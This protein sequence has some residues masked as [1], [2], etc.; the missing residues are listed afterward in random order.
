MVDV[1]H[2]GR[3]LDIDIEAM[4]ATVEPNVP[5]DQLVAATLKLG[6]VPL[7][8]MEFPG[9]TVGG[10]LQGGAGESSSFKW[11]CFNRSLNWY[12]MVLADGKIVQASPHDNNDLYFGSAGA[13]GS[14]GVVTA[15]EVKLMKAGKF[16]T[17]TYVPV[18]SFDEAVVKLK[19]VARG[20]IDFV[21]GIMFAKDR[22][23]IVYG[24]MS[25]TPIGP[26]KHY[27]HAWNQWFY[28]GVETAIK[29]NKTVA[30]SVPLVDYLFR[31]DRGAFW[32]GRYAFKRFGV[33]FNRLTRWLFNPFFKTRRM[34]VALDAS[35]LAQEY[36][37]QDLALP[38]STTTEFMNWVDT[39]MGIY[40][41]WLCPF[42]PDNDSFLQPNYLA[43][44]TIV[45]VGVWGPGPRTQVEFVTLNRALEDKVATLGG[46]KWLYAHAYYPERAF[47]N[48]YD[49]DRYD[50]LR[51]KYNANTLPTVYDKTHVGDKPTITISGKRGV[52]RAITGR[53]FPD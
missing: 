47:W 28:L 4:A 11:G 13:Y 18:S 43:V 19:E 10:G 26:V 30:E 2:L 3:I 46:R 45:N 48:I 14:L 37:V 36:I 15:A 49:K 29:N 33:P 27:G 44:D 17:L 34:Y 22:G 39:N 6:L 24:R 25:D 35:G 41:L 40:P 23:V 53:R 16:A 50:T 42:L 8:V 32:T 5:M 7:V 31:Y 51:T 38:K 12:E 52:W 9:I 1:S 20:D 21:D